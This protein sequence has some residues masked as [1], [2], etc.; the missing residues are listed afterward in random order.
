MF[1]SR[2]VEVQIRA[3]GI[4]RDGTLDGRLSSSSTNI[5]QI[6]DRSISLAVR[7][8]Q[9]RRDIEHRF[10]NVEYMKLGQVKTFLILGVLTGVSL[11]VI[12][13]LLFLG[14][15]REDFL[16]FL[17]V[18]FL[19][20][21]FIP[22]N[23]LLAVWYRAGKESYARRVAKEEKDGIGKFE[24]EGAGIVQDAM[25]EFGLGDSD[26][27]RGL[28]RS[29]LAQFTEGRSGSLGSSLSIPELEEIEKQVGLLGSGSQS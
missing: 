12:T 4:D 25:N 6:R 22:L 26:F 5:K 14:I 7:F 3:S 18:S 16:L 1:T 9:F 29:G 21:P 15:T 24:E 10:E 13:W 17:T 23:I 2:R 27:V 19:F 28:L 11:A 8:R 20:F